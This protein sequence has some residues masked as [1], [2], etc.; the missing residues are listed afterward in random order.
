MKLFLA[1]EAK[2]PESVNKLRKFMNKKLEECSVVYIPTAAN[3]EGWGTWEGGGSITLARELWPNVKIIQLEDI[4]R[5]QD[6]EEVIGV[7]DILWMAGG[8]SGYLLYWIRR[9]KLDLALP[10]ILAKGT[11]YVGSS[12]GSMVCSKTNYLAEVFPWEEETGASIIPGLGLVDF[13]IFPHFEDEYIEMLE[14]HWDKGKLYLL[15]NGDVIT[16]IDGKVEVLGEERI[17]E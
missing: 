9:T 4:T 3:G 14:K 15:K 16:V 6:I 2:H 8:M 7:P 17:F 11:V 10:K 1:A 5:D 13:E 12:A